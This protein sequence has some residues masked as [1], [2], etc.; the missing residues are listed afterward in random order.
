MNKL[1]VSTVALVAASGL[2]INAMAQAPTCDDLVW[3]ADALENNS[4]VANNCLEV[5]DRNGT[6]HAKTT[7]KIVRQGVQSTMIRFKNRDGTWS[8]EE[9]AYAPEGATA[10]ISGKEVR[11]A[12]LPADQEV[13]IYLTQQGNFDIPTLKGEDEPAE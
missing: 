9:R 12:E 5:V 6:W 2:S 7:A 3:T 4:S 10:Q 13:N 8:T 1:I 11:I